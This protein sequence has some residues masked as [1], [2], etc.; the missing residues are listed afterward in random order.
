MYPSQ[1]SIDLWSAILPLLRPLAIF[2]KQSLSE[3]HPI[4][5]HIWLYLLV[6]PQRISRE[7][8]TCEIRNPVVIANLAMFE[9]FRPDQSYEFFDF[10]RRIASED[11][12]RCL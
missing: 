12:G 2:G 5:L 9:R 7:A 10:F 1:R 3:E 4:T 11:D 8:G 6:P